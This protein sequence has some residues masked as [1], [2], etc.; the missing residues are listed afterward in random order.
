MFT[1]HVHAPKLFSNFSMLRLRNYDPENIP[2]F[3]GI[4]EILHFFHILGSPQSWRTGEKVLSKRLRH[5][6]RDEETTL[7]EREASV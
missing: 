6:E 4:F 7:L 2:L 1:G 3:Q 5:I